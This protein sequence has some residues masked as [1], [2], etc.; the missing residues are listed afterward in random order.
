[1]RTSLPSEVRP[2][3]RTGGRLAA[4]D[5]AMD[6]LVVADTLTP[7]SRPT[8]QVAE[9]LAV[10]GDTYLTVAELAGRLGVPLGTAQ[11]LASDLAA[12]GVVRLIGPTSPTDTSAGDATAQWTLLAS[13]LDG[14][15]D[16]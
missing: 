9:V 14:I 4:P 8:G 7:T 13:V 11:V 16:L 12:A 6:A 2:Y 3:V 10:L 5:V 1:M 15:H